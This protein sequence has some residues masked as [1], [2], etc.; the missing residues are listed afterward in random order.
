MAARNDPA[1]GAP[2]SPLS[3]TVVTANIAGA[4]FGC[5]FAG[6]YLLSDLAYR[7]NF[8][9]CKLSIF[10]NAWDIRPEHRSAIKTKL[11]KD[12][13]VLFWLYCAGMFDNGRE[14]R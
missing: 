13:K 6:F 1:V 14:P 5:V 3:E 2:L 7:D 4:V 8:P 9:D 12:G 10:L 11:Q